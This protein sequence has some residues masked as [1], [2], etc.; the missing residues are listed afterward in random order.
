MSSTASIA[1][2]S[3]VYALA[4]TVAASAVPP[5]SLAIDSTV[6]TYYGTPASDFAPQFVIAIT[7]LTASKQEPR[8][9]GDLTRFEEFEI[10]GYLWGGI[11]DGSDVNQQLCATFLAQLYTDLDSAINAD[12]SL[13][14]TVV[15]SWLSEFT[16]AFDPEVQGR[17]VQVAFEIHCEAL[18][19]YGAEMPNI[20]SSAPTPIFVPALG[21]V[22]DPNV[23]YTVSDAEAAELSNHP[24]ISVSPNPVP[25]TSRTQAPQH[26]S[27]I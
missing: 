25:D 1:A 2:L 16:L 18:N 8:Y 15:S 14:G 26:E 9:M 17:A 22:L 23:D 4:Q 7:G 3:K 24:W 12:P 11:E 5:P 10:E 6:Y 21:R 27:E 20:R 13:G 19:A